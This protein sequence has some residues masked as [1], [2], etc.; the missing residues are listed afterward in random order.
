MISFSNQ[1]TDNERYVINQQ[2][3]Q[4]KL[5]WKKCANYSQVVHRR[6]LQRRSLFK[7]LRISTFLWL[8]IYN[9]VHYHY[10]FRSIFNSVRWWVFPCKHVAMNI[11]KML[12]D[13]RN[14]WP[15][16][17]ETHST[18]RQGDKGHK[19]CLSHYSVKS[20]HTTGAGKQ[21]HCVAPDDFKTKPAKWRKNARV[22]NNDDDGGTWSTEHV[23]IQ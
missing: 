10:K 15:K 5:A 17:K 20:E 18:M 14:I 21:R 6:L 3:R 22:M 9:A 2:Q 16:Q 23:N 1:D 7:N 12:S 4:Y 19:S 13:Q 11:Y 8:Q